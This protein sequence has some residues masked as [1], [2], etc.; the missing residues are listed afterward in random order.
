MACLPPFHIMLRWVIV[1]ETLPLFPWHNGSKLII[2]FHTSIWQGFW[3]LH[4]HVE[5]KDESLKMGV[6]GEWDDVPGPAQP[7]PAGGP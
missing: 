1:R 7:S 4:K 2:I 3:L 5:I 6:K